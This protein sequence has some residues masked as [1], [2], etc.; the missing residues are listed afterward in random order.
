MKKSASIKVL[1]LCGLIVSSAIFTLVVFG[2]RAPARIESDS[3]KL[4]R[5]MADIGAV[6]HPFTTNTL[7]VKLQNTA[8]RF[9]SLDDY[10][11]KIVFL[12]FWT[13]WCP[14]CTTEMPAMEKLHRKLAGKN[15]AML[16]VNVKESASRVKS[17]FDKNK[18][19]F[20]A[21]L[22]T[23]GEAGTE[24]GL[25]VIPTTFILDKSG[26]IIGRIA[27]PR[28]WD[29]QNSVAL[30]ERLAETEARGQTTRLHPADAGLRRGRQK[31]DDKQTNI[32]GR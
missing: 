4:D 13:T 32:E 18:L 25:R 21:L 29:S 27:G 11:G 28:E 7:A 24:F 8:G 20:T 10:R 9:V 31:T 30:F 17:F 26:N 1:I 15:F 14:T 19:T 2:N 5:L 22:D 16:A 3:S 23:T 6:A 12:S